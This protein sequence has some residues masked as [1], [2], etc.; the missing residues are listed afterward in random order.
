VL[1]VIREHSNGEAQ[2]KAI[3]RYSQEVPARPE[4]VPERYILE[5]GEEL[6]HVAQSL[7]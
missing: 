5:G 3:Q 1:G 2:S 7:L 4:C 6:G